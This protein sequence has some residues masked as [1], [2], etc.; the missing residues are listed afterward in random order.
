MRPYNLCNPNVFV[1]CFCHGCDSRR[2]SRFRNHDF[3]TE[4][5]ADARLGD[6]P[7]EGASAGRPFAMH[8]LLP[9]SNRHSDRCPSSGSLMMMSSHHENGARVSLEMRSI[10]DPTVPEL[11]STGDSLLPTR[12][13]SLGRYEVG[14]NVTDGHGKVRTKSVRH[15]LINITEVQMTENIR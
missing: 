14:R 7:R 9:G 10:K 12:S 3:Q 4:R 1:F 2:L 8:G 5:G 13:I 6:S 11:Q 15:S